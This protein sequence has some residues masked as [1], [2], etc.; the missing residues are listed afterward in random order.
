MENVRALILSDGKVGHLNQ[1][2]ALCR[3]KGWCYDI[4]DV[5]YKSKRYKA[6]SYACDFLGF[7][8]ATLYEMKNIDLQ[9][10]DVIVA[11]GSST[12]YPAKVLSESVKL[13]KI[14]IMLPKGYRYDFDYIIA[15]SHDNPPKYD[16]VVEVPI[17]LVSHDVELDVH[18]MS[19]RFVFDDHCEYVGIVIGGPNG[20]FKMHPDDFSELFKHLSKQ[21]NTKVL[22]STSRRTPKEIE[23]WLSEQKVDFLLKYSEDTFNPI[24]FF[25]KKC[26]NI[27]I[28]SDSTSMISEAIASDVS[29]VDV[30]MLK[31]INVS[32]FHK[33]IN[34]LEELGFVH[35]FDGS[36]G[37][38]KKKLEL[39]TYLDRVCI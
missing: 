4:I 32:K 33:F 18:E 1:S 12:Y 27:I 19:K 7:Y 30:L 15:Q 2:L 3:F 25:L 23:D 14:A 22:V 8:T 24:P 31:S 34:R 6:L 17:N 16:N 10:Y 11:T 28:T 38:K 29:S 39:K 9:T 35:I 13:K 5:K 37:V 20:T 21:Q 36:L 26:K